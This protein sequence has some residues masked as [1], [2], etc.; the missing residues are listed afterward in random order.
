MTNPDLRHLIYSELLHRLSIPSVRQI[1]LLQANLRLFCDTGFLTNPFEE[2]ENGV[3]F[4]PLARREAERKNSLIRLELGRIARVT[5][6]MDET[7]QPYGFTFGRFAIDYELREMFGDSLEGVAGFYLERGKWRLHLPKFVFLLPYFLTRQPH[8][9]CGIIC[10]LPNELNKYFL[11]SS[12]KLPF[13]AAAVPLGL[14][15][16]TLL[17]DF[18]G[19]QRTRNAAD[20]FGNAA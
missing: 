2:D 12:A 14:N 7:R 5:P 18:N 8:L 3:A 4:T 1:D 11:L 10:V 9:I 16:K 15:T 19:K 17:E 13:G 6:E 20:S